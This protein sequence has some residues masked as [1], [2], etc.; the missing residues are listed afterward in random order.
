MRVD[1]SFSSTEPS[2]PVV[3]HTLQYCH[4]AIPQTARTTILES[5]EEP[6]YQ[7]AR[8]S[9]IRQVFNRHVMLE[10]GHRPMPSR[11][12]LQHATMTIEQRSLGRLIPSQVAGYLI[13]SR[14]FTPRVVHRLF[15]VA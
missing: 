14:R 3:D 6:G 5:R 13:T 15:P 4:K 1:E 10:E 2:A 11:H 9:L 7:R 8:K 12:G